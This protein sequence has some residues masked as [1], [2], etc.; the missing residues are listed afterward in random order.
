MKFIKTLLRVL[1]LKQLAVVPP[2]V[3]V[4]PAFTEPALQTESLEER[5]KEHGE[6]PPV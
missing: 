4:A 3:V 6:S 1:T 2:Q 5:R